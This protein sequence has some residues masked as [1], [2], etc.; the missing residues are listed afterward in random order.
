M[1][2]M[3]V[4]RK[5]EE[6]ARLYNPENLAPFPFEKIIKEKTDLD[7]FVSDELPGDEISGVINY[8]FTTNKFKILVNEKRSE[9]FQYFII[10]YEL[11][12]YF[13]HQGIIKRRGMI[14]D[15]GDFSDDEPSTYPMEGTVSY[16]P[17]IIKAE[18]NQFASILI[19]PEDL[20]VKA[21]NSF[22]NVEECAKIFKVPISI[23]SLRLEKLGLIT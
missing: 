21:W 20:V 11:G 10:A 9:A 12:H 15:R 17:S 8:D 18:A 16:L 2:E 22:K 6:I 19:M 23:M 7:V 1:N 5:A 13:L 14:V 4:K 3:N